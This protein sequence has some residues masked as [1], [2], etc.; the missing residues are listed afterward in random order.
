MNSLCLTLNSSAVPL[1]STTRKFFRR[2][3][4]CC[5]PVLI[6]QICLFVLTNAALVFAEDSDQALYIDA[7]GHVGIGTDNPQSQLDVTGDAK[8]GRD[9]KVGG[10]LDVTGDVKV[11]GDTKVGKQLD[12]AGDAKVGGQLT[13]NGAIIADNSDIYFTNTNHVHTGK[14]NK[15]GFAAIEN[16]SNYNCLMILG[17]NTIKKEPG[18]PIKRMVGLWD[19]LN[20]HGTIETQKLRLGGKWLLSGDGDAEANDDWLRL[21]NAKNP[22]DYYGGFAAYRLWCKGGIVK[23]SDKRLKKNIKTLNN[24]LEKITSLR[25]VNF[26]WKDKEGNQIG[27]I[28][29]EVEK[30]FPEFVSIGPDNNMKGIDY[31]SLVAPLIEAV[32]ELKKENKSLIKRVE[33]LEKS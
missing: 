5:T 1:Q 19:Y 16:S 24:S 14:G 21:K 9:T 31:S 33:L 23:G 18:K 28:A 17:R 26:E 3:I 8:V 25:G 32:K 2:W 11:G 22:K 20:V 27:L 30:V 4:K 7:E 10:Q 12:V 15:L 29:Q 6:L 13:I